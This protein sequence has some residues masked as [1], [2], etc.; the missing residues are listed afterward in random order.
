MKRVVLIAMALVMMASMAFAQA[1]FIGI[2]Q[3]PA[4]TS[5]DIVAAPFAVTMVY[6]V[7]QQTMSAASQWAVENNNALLLGVGAT[8]GPGMLSLGDPF[9]GVSVSYGGCL[10]GPIHL[11][12]LSMFNQDAT[13]TCL[14]MTVIPD[15]VVVSGMI[16]VIDC[17]LNTI[18]SSG[19]TSFVNGNAGCLCMEPT[20]SEEATWGQIKSLYN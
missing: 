2:Y 1:G 16:E 19:V 5:C 7:H 9:V 8:P 15:E 18:F 12:T 3:E 13:G 20:G 14:P 10:E 6:V 11:F 17:D 4:G